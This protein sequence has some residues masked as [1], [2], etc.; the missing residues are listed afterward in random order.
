MSESAVYRNALALDT[1]LG[2][3]RIESVLGAGGFGHP[4]SSASTA[5]SSLTAPATW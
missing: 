1:M 4:T 2:E 3:Y 5:I